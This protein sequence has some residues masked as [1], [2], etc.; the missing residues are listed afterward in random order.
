MQKY[1]EMGMMFRPCESGV[2]GTIDVWLK[3]SKAGDPAESA[4]EPVKKA[5]VA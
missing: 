5:S 1:D 3:Q 4:S 2:I